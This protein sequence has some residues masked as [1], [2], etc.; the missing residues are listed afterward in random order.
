LERFTAS[1]HAS[2]TRTRATAGSK[3]N[4]V[5]LEGGP[6]YMGSESRESFPAD[7]EGPVRRVSLSPFFISKYA[8][9]N[10]Q[11]A[12]FVR[13]VKF[14]TEAERFGW[15]FVFRN[16]SG[17][18]SRRTP[19]CASSSE[20]RR[21]GPAPPGTP[22]WVRVDGSDWS[23][24]EGPD[25]SVRQRPQHPVVHVTWNDAAAYCA[26][27]G[28]R[29]PTEAEWEYA[30]RGGLE[31][32]TYPWG[33]DLTPDGGQRCNIWQGKFP[34]FDLGETA[35]RPLRLLTPLNLT[36]TVCTTLWAMCGNGAQTIW[37]HSGTERRPG[38]TP[39]TRPR[40][41]AG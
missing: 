4:M 14:R 23:H 7:G 26:W 25:S 11:F 12:G 19:F 8:V 18:G 36:I 34:D 35:L 24:P 10:E 41:I 32:K 38:S 29:L 15:S 16:E 9:T 6:L 2:H 27:A 37:I 13:A 33:D 21:Q 3:E 28:Y 39:S 17:T 20:E 31:Q 5:H 1:I 22:W 30:S 40:A